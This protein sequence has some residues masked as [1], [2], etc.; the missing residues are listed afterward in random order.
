MKK[1]IFFAFLFG[2]ASGLPILLADKFKED[3]AVLLT[4]VDESV[5]ETLGEEPYQGDSEKPLPIDVIGHWGEGYIDDLYQMGYVTGYENGDFKPD[6]QITRAEL[7]KISLK[8]FG[9]TAVD[10]GEKSTFLDVKNDDWFKPY[11]DYAYTAGIVSGYTNHTFKPNEYVTR[12]GALKIILETAGFTEI[13]TLTPNFNDVDTVTDW[14][15]KYSAFAM[16]HELMSG[17]SDGTFGGNNNMTRAEAC[18]VIVTVIDYMN[19]QE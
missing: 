7:L 3:Q 5:E 17:Y 11:V 19:G 8:A 9:H 10:T 1:F 2:I 6:G 15:A 4:E 14:Y 12:G 13:T 16:A 18:K